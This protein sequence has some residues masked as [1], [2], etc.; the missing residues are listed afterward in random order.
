MMFLMMFNDKFPSFGAGGISGFGPKLRSTSKTLL[1]LILS[2]L[3]RDSVF[4][5]DSIDNSWELTLRPVVSCGVLEKS[6]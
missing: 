6:F 5:N 1:I 3:Y 4:T 2:F